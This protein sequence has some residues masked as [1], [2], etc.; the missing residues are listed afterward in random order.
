MN[1]NA[2]LD[3]SATRLL[4]GEGRRNRAPMSRPKR[5]VKPI[6]RLGSTSPEPPNLPSLEDLKRIN[7]DFEGMQVEVKVVPPKGLGVFAKRLLVPRYARPV[8]LRL[9]SRSQRAR[10]RPPFL[11]YSHSERPAFYLVKRFKK[12]STHTFSN[13]AINVSTSTIGDYCNSTPRVPDPSTN[14]PYIGHIVNEPFLASGQ[15]INC[16]YVFDKGHKLPK[17]F[18]RIAIETTRTVEVGDELCVD[19]GRHYLRNY[20]SIH[21]RVCA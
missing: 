14:T 21:D 3:G 12:T 1:R 2:N 20:P 11:S 15:T 8:T 19:Y 5:Q 10:H 18:V 17:S 7:S 4:K 16:R 6:D 9:R 13:F